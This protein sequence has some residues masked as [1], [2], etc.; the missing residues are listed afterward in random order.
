MTITALI[1]NVDFAPVLST[2]NVTHEITFS[3]VVSSLN[4]SDRAFGKRDK[5]IISFSLFPY[6]EEECS[7]YY[8]ALSA[9]IVSFTFTDSDGAIKEKEMRLISDL[10]SIFLLDSVDGK[11]RYKGATITLRQTGVD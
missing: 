10:E 5:T 6:T 4:G 1:N 9:G 11:R 7:A 2:W 8:D 3:K